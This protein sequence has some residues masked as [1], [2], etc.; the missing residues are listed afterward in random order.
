MKPNPDLSLK[1]NPAPK[2]FLRK[3]SLGLG[4]LAIVVTLI[5]AYIGADPATHL[6]SFFANAIA[7]DS[8]AGVDDQGP[9]G[10][11]VEGGGRSEDGGAA[12]EGS[13]CAEQLKHAYWI[14]R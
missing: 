9:D 2:S 1:P 14:M 7:A 5:V 11:R 3:H 6:G 8:R 12:C 4:A 10:S 13:R